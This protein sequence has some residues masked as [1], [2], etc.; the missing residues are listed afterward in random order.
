[1]SV[2][3]TIRTSLLQE[4]LDGL[5]S[6]ADE[7]ADTLIKSGLKGRRAEACYCPVANYV[8]HEMPE[9]T[10]A[11]VY[12]FVNITDEH[13]TSLRTSTPDPVFDFIHLFDHN[14]FPELEEN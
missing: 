3:S 12:E 7:V 10:F 11:S 8:R 14:E 4:V 1:M 2:M 5:G 13:G 6:T 9:V